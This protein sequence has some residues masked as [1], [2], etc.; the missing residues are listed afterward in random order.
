M[1]DGWPQDEYPDDWDSRRKAVYARDN[2]Q[3][4]NCG[5][6]GGPF[7]NTE[8]HCHHIVPKS[9][10][11]SHRKRN[12]TTLCRD[13]HNKAH[14]HHIP[15]MSKV[16]G[17]HSSTSSPSSHRDPSDGPASRNLRQIGKKYGQSQSSVGTGL[18]TSAQNSTETDSPR[19]QQET[20]SNTN[21]GRNDGSSDLGL[22]GLLKEF[23]RYMGMWILVVE[24]LFVL[25]HI[26][27]SEPTQSFETTLIGGF[28]WGC[29]A[30]LFL[31][32]FK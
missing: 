10:G 29:I 5:A 18:T 21:I 9:E 7:G 23:A 25:T 17:G 15:E 24:L 4:Q 22:L 27:M 20:T 1:G 2:H 6:K 11:G 8:L 14:D 19:P 16:A 28:V 3:C 30:G 13:C 32:I 31:L 12:L 26:A